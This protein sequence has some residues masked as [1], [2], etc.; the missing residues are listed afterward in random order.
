M[1]YAEL[2]NYFTHTDKTQ[3]YLEALQ[4]YLF[5]HARALQ[6]VSLITLWKKF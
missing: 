3:C 4:F 5:Y 6:V 1:L 2:L